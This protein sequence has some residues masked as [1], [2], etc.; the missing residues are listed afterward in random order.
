M[1]ICIRHFASSL[2]RIFWAKIM[3]QEFVYEVLLVLSRCCFQHLV[4]NSI[5]YNKD[6]RLPLTVR[7]HSLSVG[8]FSRYLKTELFKRAY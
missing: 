8:Q 2:L 4:E 5:L 6:I 1:K 3:F 7:D